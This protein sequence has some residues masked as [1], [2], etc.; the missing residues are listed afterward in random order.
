MV[1]RAVTY[2]IGRRRDN[3]IYEW[4]FTDA[5]DVR[6]VHARFSRHGAEDASTNRGF[7]CVTD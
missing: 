7:S 6:R 4:H 2:L 3:V 1:T 5:D